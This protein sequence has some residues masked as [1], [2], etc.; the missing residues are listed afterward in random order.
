MCKNVPRPE[1]PNPQVERSD[2]INL[3]GEW[4]FEIDNAKSGRDRKLNE[5]V[6]LSGK[7]TVPFSPESKLSG[8]G[9][10]DFMYSVWYRKE[11]IIDAGKLGGRVML[12]FGAVDYEAFV[13]INGVL[14]GTHKGGYVHFSFDI[15]ELVREGKN[16]VTVC[17]EDDTKDALIPSGKQSHKYHSHG[18]HYTRTTGIWQTVW[19]EFV[20]EVHIKSF[21]LFPDYINGAVDIHAVVTGGG[22]LFAKAL[23]EGRHVGES[24]KATDGGLVTLR[25]ELSE[26]HLWEVGAG[27][28]YDLELSIG[29][30]N[31]K[32][33]FGLRGVRMD[34]FKFTL[35]GKPVFM[36]LVLDQGYYP[37]G[38]YTAAADDSFVRDI[39]ISIA[40]GFNGAR[41]HE[42]VFEP[43]FLYHC[44]KMGYLVWGEY[45]NW[46]IDYSDPRCVA[47]VLPEWCEVLERDF[48]HPSIIGWCPF[49][50]TWD[51]ELKKQ[52]DEL[53]R[54]VYNVT[55][56][57]DPTRPCIDTSGNYHVVT[58]IYDVHDYDQ[59]PKSFKE[60]YDKLMTEGILY[61]KVGKHGGVERQRRRNE[62]TFV[63]EYGGIRWVKDGGEGWGYGDAPRCEREF[64]DRYKGLTDALLDNYCM[65][66]FCYTQLYD[67]EQEKN[68]LYTYDRRPK[69]DMEFF[70]K[71]NSRAAAAEK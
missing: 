18:C 53:L 15:T 39:E 17:A 33:Y 24:V 61:D 56:L 11:F 14:V 58:D 23:F 69:F 60:N 2:W 26:K 70:K 30:D 65:C 64:L 28:L 13:Y 57:L 52:W 8:V 9:N 27:N 59:D 51:Y 34:G 45:P 21:K 63:S 19:L 42:K 10:V 50:E 12:H 31:V 5:A 20:P 44:D 54:I 55:K 38:I 25:I 35:N 62:P 47:S 49:N 6:A 32:S 4:E 1:Y 43:R 7:I 67:V 36:R 29:G 22:T 3:N 16:V 37:D 48:N 41:L 68:G 66:G 40:A 71:V 46:G